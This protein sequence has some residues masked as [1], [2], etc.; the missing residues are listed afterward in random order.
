MNTTHMMRK[1]MTAACGL[2]LGASAAQAADGTW[3]NLV[4]ANPAGPTQAGQNWSDSTKWTGNI[5]AGTVGTTGSPDT[6]FMNTDNH[7]TITIDGNYNVSNLYHNVV[8]HRHA[9]VRALADTTSVLS[10][11]GGGSIYGNSGNLHYYA[12]VRLEG[13]SGRSYTFNKAQF[14]VYAPVTGT[15]ATGGNYDLFL[16]GSGTFGTTTITGYGTYTG[17]ITDGAGGGTLSVIKTGTGIWTLS[18]ASTYT[19]TTTVRQGTLKLGH[20]NGFGNPS[21]PIMLGDSSTGASDNLELHIENGTTVSSAY[22]I[23]VN[24]YGNTVTLTH[25][26]WNRTWSGDIDLSRNIDFAANQHILTMAGSISGIAGFTKTGGGTINLSSA[27]TYQGATTVSAG[28]LE[29]SVAGALASS[30]VTVNGGALRANQSVGLGAANSLSLNGGVWEPSTAITRTTGS[31]ANQ[32]QLAGTS[33]FSAVG[34]AVNVNLNSGAG[35]VWGSTTGFNPATLVLNQTTA[36]NTLTLQ[37]ALDLNGANRTVAVNASAANTAT[38][39]GAIGNSSGTAGLTKSGAGT[40]NLTGLNT[41]NGG[42]TLNGGVLNVR[43][44][45]TLVSAV[46][47]NAGTLTVDYTGQNTGASLIP[48]TASLTLGGGTFSVTGSGVAGQTTAQTV[49]GLTL[50][51]RASTVAA[52]ASGGRPVV[53]DLGAIIRSSDSATVNF[54]LPAGTQDAANGIL[55]SSGSANTRLGMW[56]TVNG[57]EW[58]AKDAENDN[59]V[60]WSSVGGT[61]TDVTRLSSGAKTIASNPASDVRIIDGTGTPANIT[62]AAAGTTDIATLFA[63]VTGG[64]ATYDPDTADI[65]RLSATG[66]VALNGATGIG[67]LTIGTAANDGVLTAGGAADTAGTITFV[68]NSIANLITVNSSIADN[69]TGA[70]GVRKLGPGTLAFDGTSTVNPPSLGHSGGTFIDEG[71]LRFRM[72][73]G[74][75]STTVDYQIGTGSIAFQG[76]TLHADYAGNGRPATVRITNPIG[77]GASGATFNM[78]Q[79]AGAGHVTFTGAQTLGGNVRIEGQAVADRTVMTTTLAGPITLTNSASITFVEP[80]YGFGGLTWNN[81]AI[82]GGVMGSSHSLTFTGPG[83]VALS[84]GEANFA[85]ANFIVDNSSTLVY[86][87]GN[88]GDFFSGV[89]GNAGKVTLNAART[90]TVTGQG[91]WSM[92]DFVFNSG[93][94]LVLDMATSRP[95]NDAGIWQL[96]GSFT[97]GT[98]G[99]GQPETLRWIL[100]RV[101]NFRVRDGASLGTI[102][103]GNSG[104]FQTWITESRYDTAPAYDGNLRLHGGAIL[105]GRM[106]SGS[107]AS[108]GERPSGLRRAA[109]TLYLGDGDAET[110]ETVTIQG[111]TTWATNLKRPYFIDFANNTTDDGNVVIRYASVGTDASQYFNVGWMHSGGT[112]VALREGSAGTV[113]APA[114]QSAGVAVVGPAAGTV[115]TATKPVTVSTAGTVGFHNVANLGGTGGGER[116]AFGPLEIAATGSLAFQ[117]AGKVQAS[118]VTFK[119]GAALNVRLTGASPTAC[120]LVDASG[121]LTFESGTAITITEEPGLDAYKGP[122]YVAKGATLSGLPKK[123]AGLYSVT[124][125]AGYVRIDR[126]ASGTVLLLR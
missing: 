5:I 121:T 90:L 14:T 16:N 119:T 72:R 113:F 38:I 41:F 115:F 55:T 105:D 125:E 89:R 110:A 33:G 31:G 77:V 103:V 7:Y 118:D 44:T 39:S 122:W 109:G 21:G 107:T 85:P 71:T 18:N 124:A 116:G 97:I 95:S 2:L 78:R 80:T 63:G 29:S 84:N 120:S 52:T 70:V 87:T 28:V 96:N 34:G 126:L 45:N 69:G 60:P 112:L 43:N 4:N 50:A 27:N 19:G 75:N 22:D 100:H 99:A 35:L 93:S 47:A 114:T 106:I 101:Q 36:N 94:V 48:T 23:Q 42:L 25:P 81:N 76:A 74:G 9:I 79:A 56:A 83:S 49:N 111:V 53:L 11:S 117:A 102:T 20:P 58:A 91:N 98:P 82:S 104:S 65:L 10:L 64:T 108:T 61:Y 15:A 1:L 54:A 123:S 66:T 92:S 40:L 30:P 51:S 67:A 73:G 46:T 26:I 88:T 62:P 57:S 37:N 3:A 17:T 24:N 59:I 86:G 32:V 68:N 12:P 8:S 6:L 13:G